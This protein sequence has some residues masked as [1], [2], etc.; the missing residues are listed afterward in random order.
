VLC[1][2]IAVAYGILATGLVRVSL[3]LPTTFIIVVGGLAMLKVLEAAFVTAFESRHSL[4]AVVTFIVVLADA[5][6]LNIGG[7]FWGL[8]AGVAVS[9]MS[10]GNR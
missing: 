9:R 4:A 10:R 3:A 5:T 1:G 8:L 7:A 2:L 6:V